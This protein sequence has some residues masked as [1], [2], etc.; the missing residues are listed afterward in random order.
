MAQKPRTDRKP[1]PKSK[2]DP[3]ARGWLGRVVKWMVI[4]GIWLMLALGVLVAW[5]AWDLPDISRLETPSRRPSVELMTADGAVL[6]RYGDLHGGWIRFSDLPLH[7]VQAVAATE[8]RRFFEH[9]G[10]DP[11]AIL[12]AAIANIARGNRQFAR[13]HHSPGW[14]HYQPAARQK[15]VPDT[16]PHAQ[17]Q[18]PRSSRR[19]VAG[20]QFFQTA[21]LRHLCQP[22]LSRRRYLRRGGRVEALFR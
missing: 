22:G 17:A 20:S 7:L 11:W 10:V 16:R 14:L 19:A 6:A 21:N 4:A 1:A 13:W 15:P 9:R 5:Y 3:A 2:P 18:G 12:R 8:D